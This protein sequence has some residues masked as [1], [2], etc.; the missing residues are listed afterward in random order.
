MNLHSNVMITPK[1]ARVQSEIV[2]E[3]G[4]AINYGTGLDVELELFGSSVNLL[5]TLDSDL[6]ICMTL[7]NNPTNQEVN[8]KEILDRVLRQVL[9]KNRHVQRHTIMPILQAR[10]PIIK[11]KYDNFDVDLSM[12]N[13]CAIY[14]S[15]LLRNY[16]LIDNRTAQL[17]YL[18]KQYAKSCNIADASKG[19][20]SSFAWSVMVIHFLQHTQ[21]PILPHLQET[22][23]KKTVEVNGWNVWFDESFEPSS[24]ARNQT[25]LTSLFKQ[26]LLYFK[27]F[28]FEN[29][30]ISIRTSRLIT[31]SE[32]DWT[33]C[34]MAIENPF[35]LDNNLSR[36]L[37]KSMVLFI[38]NSFPRTYE[39]L[40]T[41]LNSLCRGQQV[42]GAN[43]LRM[44]F[45]GPA[46]TGSE[47]PVRGCPICHRVGHRVKDCPNK[48]KKGKRR[49]PNS[50]RV[51]KESD[52]RKD[53]KQQP[54]KKNCRSKVKSKGKRKQD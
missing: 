45:N 29:H 31:K 51:R 39:Y 42:P 53:D 9:R 6:D 16:V 13:H 12:C 34:A 10:V 38:L 40:R 21:P 22:G 36:H 23:N 47:P 7:R 27:A 5:G 54:K 20:L 15:R 1:R 19:S 14:N 50:S 44:L 32:K 46:I 4:E 17:H 35:E 37:D 26:F 24:M 52:N 3:L 2:S 41:F 8:R 30:V 25:G 33:S 43:V 18:V 28:D 48:L 49:K 11:F